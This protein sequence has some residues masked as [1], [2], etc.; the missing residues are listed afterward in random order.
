M[1][2]TPEKLNM[3]KLLEK[4][5]D[6]MPFYIKEALKSLFNYLTKETEDEGGECYF[7]RKVMSKIVTHK[8]GETANRRAR[9]LNS[10]IL[11]EDEI[12]AYLKFIDNGYSETLESAEAKGRYERDKIRDLAINTLILGTGMRVGEIASIEMK[13]IHL[14]SRYIDIVRKG[15]K[16]D[17]MSV[18]EKYMDVRESR[19]SSA[20]KS[21][22]LSVFMVELLDRYLEEQFK[23][24]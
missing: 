6:S 22:F 2:I 17:S 19:Y 18:L 11:N 16:P 4:H 10:I 5:S 8:K 13:N 24:L 14:H 7:Y 12:S 21:P 23:T 20:Q 1:A 9:D 3:R 15:N